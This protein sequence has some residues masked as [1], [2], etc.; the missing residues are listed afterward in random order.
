MALVVLSSSNQSFWTQLKIH[1][2]QLDFVP[3]IRLQDY[4]PK[5]Q[6]AFARWNREPKAISKFQISQNFRNG[7]TFLLESWLVNRD[8]YIS[9][10]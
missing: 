1:L 3:L 8:P 4:E 9:L 5:P 2:C 6:V 7:L 10:L